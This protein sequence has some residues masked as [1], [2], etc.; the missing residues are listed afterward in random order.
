MLFF[1]RLIGTWSTKIDAYIA[2][3]EFARDKFIQ[4][5]LPADR[6]VVK[7]IFVM[8]HGIGSAE[9]NYAVF[10][11]RLTEEKG[12]HV[13][14]EAWKVLGDRIPL[15][16]AGTGPLVG[17]VK[18]ST[19]EIPGV[20]YLGSLPNDQ[21]QKI[22]LRAAFSVF[23]SLWYEGMPTVILESYAAGVPVI[24]SRLGSMASM[25]KQGKTGYLFEPGDVSGLIQTVEQL[26][27]DSADW[28]KMRILARREYEENYTPDKNYEILMSIYRS[29][30]KRRG[31]TVQSLAPQ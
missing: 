6:I 7:P 25:V 1:H 5:G 22:F 24:S 26:C 13:L 19:T 3:T 27:A 2:L 10:A 20:S 21:L 4:G 17:A 15:K 23:P 31:S 30:T 18:R 11:G 28:Q 12:V 9:D 14:L 8:D 29:T 16:I